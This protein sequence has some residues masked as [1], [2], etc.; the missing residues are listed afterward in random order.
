MS[1]FYQPHDFSQYTTYQLLKIAEEAANAAANK[2]KRDKEAI[3]KEIICMASE[4]GF[5]IKKIVWE[6]KEKSPPV[7]RDPES[8]KTFSGIGRPPLWLKKHGLEKC[9]I[10]K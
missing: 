8:G 6:E 9:R 3:S 5:P 1:S 4:A 10:K 2:K 7:Y